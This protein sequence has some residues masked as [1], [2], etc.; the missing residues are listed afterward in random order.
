MTLRIITPP[1]VEPVSVA[2]AMAWSRIDASNQ[3]PAP[4]AISAALAGT[5]IAGNVD[6]GAHRYLATFVTASGETQAGSVSA[7]VTVVDKTVNGRVELTGI[8]LGGALVISRKI[9]RT[10]AGGSTYLLLTTIADNTTTV[11]TDNIADG[12]LGAGAP[13]VNTTSDPMLSM[14]ITAARSIAERKTGRALITQTWEQVLDAFPI[15]LP[16]ALLLGKMPIQSVTSLKFY[17]SNGT[18]Q[19]L[20]SSK[21]VLDADTQPGWLLPVL[22]VDWPN[23]ADVAN[24][25]IARFVVGYGASGASV[26]REILMWISAQVKAAYDNPSGLLDGEAATLPFLDGLLDSYRVSWP[27]G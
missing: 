8:P 20:D 15:G 26:P 9:Y 10:A 27:P 16:N 13:S 21:Y 2:E 6:N 23:T 24:A 7:A 4:G 17:D 11:Y 3:E 12:S 1:A 22:N 14:L 18:L 5:P 25:V 19:T